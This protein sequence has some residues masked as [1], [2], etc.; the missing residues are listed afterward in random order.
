MENWSQWIFETLGIGHSLQYKIVSTLII[1]VS[2]FFMRKLLLRFFLKKVKSIKSRYS[3]SKSFTY[4]SYL[5]I[6]ILVIPIWFKELEGLGTFFGLMAAG[7]AIALK[8]PILNLFAWIYIL[9]KKPFDVG[10]RIQIDDSAGDILD[11]SFFDFTLLE[12]QNWVDADQSTG[13]VIHVP[14]GLVFTK[15]VKNFNQAMGFIWHEIPILITFESNW[16]KAKQIL[17]DVENNQ[18]KSMVQEVEPKLEQVQR[19]YYVE[20]SKLN[21]TVYTS[22]KENGI[23][24]T[25]RFLCPPKKRRS[26]EQVAIEEILTQFSQNEDIQFAYPTTRFYQSEPE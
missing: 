23:L 4:L 3:W 26:F 7:M 24:L 12:I 8:E 16:K 20:Y 6:I 11:I 25:L 14:N 13:R 2:I 9:F 10:D 21:P 19:K 22:K 18:L 1:I 5:L 17:L 15:T